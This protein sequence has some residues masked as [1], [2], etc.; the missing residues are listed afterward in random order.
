KKLGQ[1]FGKQMK[2][3][4]ALLKALDRAQIAELERSGTVSIELDGKSVE[5][6]LSDVKVISEDMPGWL[7]ANEGALT[8]A[9][10]IDVTPELFLEGLAREIINR[11]QNIRKGRN[12]DIT[13]HI[14]LQFIDC[15]E[16]RDVIGKYGDYIAA[17]V[18]A[19][20]ITTGDPVDEHAVEILDIDELKLG[21]VIDKA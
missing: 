13:D 18:L 11:V 7:V 10:D 4:A 21:V 16:V 1:K 5:V 17:Q 12:F 9:L 2:Q 3:V 8:V 14:T 20:A 6:C 15:P 19:D